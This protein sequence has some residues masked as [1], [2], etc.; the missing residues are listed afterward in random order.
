MDSGGVASTM[1]PPCGDEPSPRGTPLMTN[2]WRWIGL[3]AAAVLVAAALAAAVWLP[4]RPVVREG[5]APPP[6]PYLKPAPT[7]GLTLHVFNTG[8]NRMSSLLVG[9]RR[10]WRPVPV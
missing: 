8:M 4:Y 2:V 5:D 9:D 3:T 6:P 1:I 10:P 7:V